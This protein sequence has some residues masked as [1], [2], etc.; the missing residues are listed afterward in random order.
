[1][2]RPSYVDLHHKGATQVPGT[3]AGLTRRRFLEAAGAA[4]LV[5]GGASGLARPARA[6][7]ELNYIGWDG[8]QAPEVVGSWEKAQDARIKFT[9]LTDSGGT[10]TKLVAGGYRDYDVITN[11]VPWIQRMGAADICRFLDAA[12]FQETYESFYPQ[13]AQ[14]FEPLMWD[15]KITG[16]PTRWGW[17]GVNIN[18]KYSKPEDWQSYAPV[19]DPANRD[20][21]GILDFGDWATFQVIL[22]AGI[23][24]FEPLDRNQL[25]EVRKVFRALFNNT[26]L[27]TADLV[28]AQRALLDG[29]ALIF[30]AGGNYITSGMRKAGNMEIV[31]FVP[32]PINGMKQG[33]T[34]LEATAVVKDAAN[35]ELAENL[36]KH[37]VSTEAG[38]ALAWTEWSACPVPNKSVEALLSDEQKAVIDVANMWTNYDR[39]LTYTVA[40][41]I[42]DILRIWQEELAR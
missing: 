15:G 20:R 17:V 36:L 7:Q 39:S 5:A 29:S 38:A 26:R 19:F 30:L 21:I 28:Q 37:L 13:F 10:F 11:D 25:D 24:P 18:T 40:P 31:S 41:N 35:P 2:K 16:L 33:V 23:N 27:I 8:Y 32:E 6:A 12:T 1:M 42:D 9:S 3:G 4:A 34:W 22:Y 14:P